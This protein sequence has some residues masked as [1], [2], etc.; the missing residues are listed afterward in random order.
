VAGSGSS[1][2]SVTTSSTTPAGSYPL[3][4]TG[5]SGSLV[6]SATGTLVVNPVGGRRR[7]FQFQRCLRRRPFHRATPR[8]S[9]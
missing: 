7:F 1:T 4:M 6:H 3:T 9:S 8:A 5:T 2:L